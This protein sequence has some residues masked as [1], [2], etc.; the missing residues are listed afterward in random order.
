MSQALP[1]GPAH[2]PISDDQDT[3]ADARLEAALSTVRSSAPDPALVAFTEA[4]FRRASPEDIL[5]YSADSLAALA[6]LAFQKSAIRKPGESLVDLFTLHAEKAECTS[7][8][9][10]LIAVNDDM[11]FL[12]DSLIGL[13]TARGAKIQALF[14][15]IMAGGRNA[16]GTRNASIAARES[17]IVV[18]LEFHADAD[19]Q[20]SL[21]A[22]ADHVFSQVRL[23]VRDWRPMREAL[24]ETILALSDNPPAISKD[25]LDESIAFLTWLGDNHFTFLGARDYAYTADD[26]GHLEPVDESGLGILANPDARVI[27]RGHGRVSLSPDVQAFLTQPEPLIITKAN[28]RS[29]VHRRVHMDYV[30]VKMFDANGVLTGERRFVGLFTSGAYSRRP[31]EIPLLRRKVRHVKERASLPP[32][33]H[34]GKALAHILDTY[35]R[36]ELFQVSDDELFAT[37]MGILRL[38]ERPKVRVF[39]RFDRFDRFVSALVFVPRDRYDTSVR[40]RIHAILAKRFDGRMSAATPLLDDSALARVHYIIGRN[41]GE[42]PRVEIALLEAEIREAIR[43]WDDGFAAALVLEH[44]EAQGEAIFRRQAQTFPHRYRDV[45][46]P[47]E[48]VTDLDELDRLA[49]NDGS[50]KIKAR[51]YRRATDAHSAIRLK[52]YVLGSVLPLS[53]SL[54]VFENLGFKVIAEDSYSVA[55]N[56]GDGW[57]EDAAVL[58]FRMERADEG[59]ADLETIKDRLEDAFHAVV[60]GQAENDGFNRL[61]IGAGLTWRDV[62]I[63]RATAKYLRQAGLTFSQDYLEQALSRNP[64]IAALLVELFVVRN[65]PEGGFDEA[66]ATQIAKRI[67]QSLNDVPSL[68]DDRIIRRLRNVIENVLRTNFFQPG[69]DGQPKSYF[70]MKLDSARLDELPAPRP[71][72]EIFVYS[73]Q[74]EG[75]HLRFGKVARGGIRWSDRREDFRTEILGLVKAQQ[76]KNAVI[77]PVGAK[78]G[79]YPKQLPLNAARDAVQAAAIEAYKTFIGALLDVTDNIGPDGSVIVPDHVRRHDE[80]DPYLVVAADKGTATFSDIANGIAESRGFWLGDAFASGGSHG[81]DH[82]KMGITARGAWEA[83]KRHFREMGRDIQSEPFTVVGVGDMSGDVFGNG[84]LLSKHIRLVAAFDHRHIFIDPDPDTAASWDERK[85]MFELPRSSWADYNHDLISQGGGVFPRTAKEIVLSPQMKALT[86][87]TA[88]KATPNDLMKALLKAE[89]DLLWFGGIGTYIKASTQNN[90]DV[91]DRAN[92]ALRVNGKDVRAKVVGEGANL[93][94]TQLGRVEYALTGG[95][96]NTD[97]ID[98]SAGVDT[99]DHE[100][101]L[102]ILF[103]GP[104]RRD[105]LSMDARDDLL[106]AMTDEV[107]R[108]V[109]QD[110]YDQTL[111]L[112]VAQSRALTDADGHARFMRELERRGRLDRAVEFLPTDEELRKRVTDGHGLTRP[113]LAVLLAY[114][115]LDLAADLLD[116]DLPDDAHFGFELKSYFPKAAADKYPGEMENHRLRREI[117]TDVLTNHMVNL[118]G[119]LFVHRMKEISGAPAPK[120]ARAFAMADGAFALSDLKARID[121][122]DLKVATNLQTAMYENIGELLRRLG[123]WFLVNVPSNADL[124]ETVKRYRQGVDLLRGTFASLVSPYEAHDTEARIN[125]YR[126]AGAPLDVAEDVAVLPL[127]GAAPEIVHLAHARSLDIDLVAGAYFELGEIIGID[128]LRGLSARI[129][130]SEHWDRL[131]IRRIADDLFAGQ[132]ALAQNALA[133]F[134]NDKTDRS[135]DD[136]MEAARQWAKSHDETLART[137]GFLGEL[138]RTGDLSIAKLT[139]ANSQIHELA[140]H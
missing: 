65:D 19:A 38:G 74:V 35:P 53:A 78:G 59:A 79:F 70:A 44:G 136:G 48:A 28:E 30:G 43:T 110:N 90:I 132:R 93:G 25:Q 10:V 83:V 86:G 118:A 7:N 46:A 76:V 17:V 9:T 89:V 126:D 117:V 73:P 21:L 75:V 34:D 15:P 5:S 140:A 31:S 119:P 37:A 138:E 81:Y 60:A 8:E 95:R 68:D 20:K 49:R 4:L 129:A 77:V 47:Q 45:F 108:H 66:R 24:A 1:A 107:A 91:G 88:D 61:V 130:A 51:A 97:A 62:T 134:E 14:H 26:G 41:E 123:L 63:L 113:E 39:L 99:S 104:T 33:S 135:R 106:T 133:G 137:R 22:E 18:A 71:H 84:M 6:L 114:S 139:L 103:S 36:D 42:R 13:L 57:Q 12:F 27:R 98:N 67:E 85:R 2:N 125:A 101:N 111:A 122:L 131:A 116:S 52:L 105:E 80:D 64:D 3:K 58:D 56:L 100:V 82:K 124:S 23:A 72:V 54:P 102:K 87:L 109:L 121:T 115:K 16:D 127:L 120:V 50:L 69:A 112:S 96:I 40:E 32:E 29:A 128:R 55:L 94:A 11:P 92:D